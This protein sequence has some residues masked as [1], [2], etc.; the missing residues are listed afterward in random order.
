MTR[1]RDRMVRAVRGYVA[2]CA[3]VDR[4][5]GESVCV[6]DEAM[7]SRYLRSRFGAVDWRVAEMFTCGEVLSDQRGLGSLQRVEDDDVG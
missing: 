5:L 1:L 4:G 7:V 3:Y 6:A 2:G